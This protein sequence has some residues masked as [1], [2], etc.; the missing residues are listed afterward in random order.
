MDIKFLWGIFF[1]DYLK[2]NIT[3]HWAA[4]IVSLASCNVYL[5]SYSCLAPYMSN[6]DFYM[7][8]LCFIAVAI[9]S[10][11]IFVKKMRS[12]NS[13]LTLS[14]SLVDRIHNPNTS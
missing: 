12:I 2:I 7:S 10:P 8:S 6:A 4:P 13:S 3:K 5:S 9:L 11:V 14:S 1:D